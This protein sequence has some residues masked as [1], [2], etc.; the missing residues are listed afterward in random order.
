ML[1]IISQRAQPIVFSASVNQNQG[2][3]HKNYA[4]YLGKK[5]AFAELQ[6]ILGVLDRF[7]NRI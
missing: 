5:I 4:E 1:I 2:G 7:C 3:F 6:L